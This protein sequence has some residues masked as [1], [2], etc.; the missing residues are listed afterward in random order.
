MDDGDVGEVD[1]GFEGYAS[2]VLLDDD[3]AATA[4]DD[5]VVADFEA[6]LLEHVFDADAVDVAVILVVPDLADGVVEGD[7]EASSLAEVGA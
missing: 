5:E 3:A 4:V 6:E 2:H 1:A 7:E